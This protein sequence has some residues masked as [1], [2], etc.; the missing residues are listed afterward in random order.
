MQEVS[1]TCHSLGKNVNLYSTVNVKADSLAVEFDNRRWTFSIVLDLEV[2]IFKQFHT[3]NFD[4]LEGVQ[5][6]PDDVGRRAVLPSI[7]AK[8]SIECLS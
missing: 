7:T 3:W 1:A 6:N 8:S 2:G 4:S 5:S